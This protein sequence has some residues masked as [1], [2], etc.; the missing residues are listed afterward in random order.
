[1]F[2]LFKRGREK[3]KIASSRDA[4]LVKTKKRQNKKRK[5]REREKRIQNKRHKQTKNEL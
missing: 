2:V 3:L 4:S 5:E 1:V